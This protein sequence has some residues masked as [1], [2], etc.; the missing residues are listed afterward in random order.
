MSFTQSMTTLI[1]HLETR[2]QQLDTELQETTAAIEVLKRLDG[3]KGDSAAP[4]AAVAS[5]S[6]GQA[7]P[8]RRGRIPRAKVEDA[9]ATSSS[10]FSPR[11]SVLRAYQGKTIRDAIKM[12]LQ[13]EAGEEFSVNDILYALYGKTI[14]KDALK[15]ARPIVLAELS[16]GKMANHWSN[17]PGRK[18]YYTF[19]EDGDSDG[20]EDDE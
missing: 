2:R 11:T 7:A 18:G 15:V 17:V 8:R 12:I 6:N 20:E 10:T 5:D 9:A 13:S 1:E 19:L 4:P 3:Q 14:S 16:K